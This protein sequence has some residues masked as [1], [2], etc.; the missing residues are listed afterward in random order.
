MYFTLYDFVSIGEGAE[1]GG[2]RD[3]RGIQGL[4]ESGKLFIFCNI[5][6]NCQ[7]FVNLFKFKMQNILLNICL[8]MFKT[9]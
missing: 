8:N 3:L 6:K 9:C 2:W 4:G 5:F 7:I 1:S